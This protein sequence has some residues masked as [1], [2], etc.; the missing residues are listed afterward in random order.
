MNGR[1]TLLLLVLATAIGA[2]LYYTP[3]SDPKSEQADDTTTVQALTF[4]SRQ[5]SAVVVTKTETGATLTVTRT[6]SGWDITTD[7]TVAGDEIVIG[8][9]VAALAALTADTV[10][11]PVTDYGIYG[12]V[13]PELIIELRGDNGVLA[14]LVVG[15]RNP[16]DSARYV[17]I[18]DQDKV[19]VVADYILDTV[20]EWFTAVPLAPTALPTLL[21]NP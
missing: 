8:P 13:T 3:A 16:T 6:A 2:Y 5:I 17:Q 21:P 1:V 12:L 20:E 7:S 4:E 9:A 15:G 18:D 14:T 19:Y 11:S 10:I